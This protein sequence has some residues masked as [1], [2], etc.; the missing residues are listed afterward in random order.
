MLFWGSQFGSQG[1]LKTKKPTPPK[2]PKSGF[3]LLIQQGVALNQRPDQTDTFAVTGESKAS[4]HCLAGRW[5]VAGLDLDFQQEG[6]EPSTDGAE[7]TYLCVVSFE[8]LADLS[9]AASKQKMATFCSCFTSTTD[10]AKFQ[11]QEGRPPRQDNRRVTLPA[12][13]Q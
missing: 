12:E 11:L 4:R 2:V 5:R 6:G 1:F 9:N 3:G 7:S 10:G 8:I 13:A